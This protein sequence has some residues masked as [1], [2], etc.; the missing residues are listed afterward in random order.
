MGTYY[1]PR[2]VKGEGRILFIFTGKSLMYTA[3]GAAIGFPIQFIVSNI[4]G[5]EYW[6]M[7]ATGLGALIG[8]IIGTLKIPKLAFLKNSQ[9]IAGENIDEIIKRYIK[10]KK[11]KNKIYINTKEEEESNDD[12]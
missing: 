11:E 3:I 8:F 9:D 12:K 5:I 7:I 2:N 4:L 6:G 10:F 1:I